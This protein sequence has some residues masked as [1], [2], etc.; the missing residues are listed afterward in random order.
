MDPAEILALEVKQFVGQ[1]MKTLVPRVIGQTET[2]LQKKTPDRV[3]SRQWD[4]ASFFEDLRQRRGEQ[5][6]VV[7][8]RLLEWANDRSLRIRW[9]KGQTEGS[10]TP[11][12]E[13]RLG[14][15]RLFSVWT[16]GGV[17]ILFEYMKNSPFDREPERKELARRLSAIEGVSIAGNALKERP[18]FPLS[19]FVEPATTEKFLTAFDWML[20]EIERAET[21]EAPARAC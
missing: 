18:T 9:G 11:V 4:E 5:E 15:N 17:S 14:T 20:S 16:S 21:D 10:L 1:N 2:A 7:A 19:L 6:A 13:N 8:R 3:E 12:Y